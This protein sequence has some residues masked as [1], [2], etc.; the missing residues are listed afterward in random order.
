[1]AADASGGFRGFL[2]SRAGRIAIILLTVGVVVGTFAYVATFLAIPMFLLVGLG[3]PIWTG[4]KRPRF[5]AVLGLV[6]LLAVAPLANLVFAQELLVP[7][8]ASASPGLGDYETGGSVLENATV[9]PFSAPAGTNFTWTVTLY[10]RYLASS[11]N[12]T[13][14]TNDSLQLYVST[15]PGATTPNAS[16]CGGS[17]TFLVVNHR[18]AGP[19]APANGT[20]VTFGQQIGADDVWS[21]QMELV[22][23]N[24][25]NASNPF[26]IE[27]SGDP[28]YDGIEGPIV[29]GYATAY[30]A[31][32][33]TIYEIDVV[34]LGI[35]FYFLLLLYAWFKSREARRKQAVKRAARTML[36]S[37]TGA[38]APSPGPP[39]TSAAGG[40]A[41]ELKCPSCGAVV[42]PNE[43]SCWK[44]G[45]ALPG[46]PSSPLP[47]PKN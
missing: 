17:Y 15:C 36:D 32:I 24:L 23:Q 35:P 42:Y 16:Y 28:G 8:P 18:F 34:Y 40:S 1:M 10:P 12:S 46:A 2:R 4:L 33:L 3:L 25:S 41:S 31:L 30:V 6:V 13:N 39:K 45:S 7:P 38:A 14:W 47:S 5:L 43:G 11:L 27:L 26:R 21:W 9:T 22:I 37:Q 20:V 19:H 44:C 29:G